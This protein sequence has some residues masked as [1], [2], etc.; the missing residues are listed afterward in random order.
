MQRPITWTSEEAR[1]LHRWTLEQSCLTLEPQQAS[2]MIARQDR[3]HPKSGRSFHGP[4][5]CCDQRFAQIPTNVTPAD[6]ETTALRG[7]GSE[8]EAAGSHADGRSLIL[9]WGPICC[10]IP[11]CHMRGT[12]CCGWTAVSLTV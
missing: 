8:I 10:K 5:F 3:G 1:C 6:C 4:L 2:S 12:Q 9:L 11:R 7:G